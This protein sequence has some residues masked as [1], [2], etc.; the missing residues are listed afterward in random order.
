MLTFIIPLL[1]PR[2]SPQWSQTIAYLRETVRSI[3]AQK[4]S[5][6]QAVVVANREAELPGLPNRVEVVRVDLEPNPMYVIG[7]GDKE[8]FYEAV[9]LDKGQRL[10][11]GMLYSDRSGHF[12]VVDADDLVSN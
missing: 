5:D 11:A 12:M 1:H 3:A 7:A 8:P 4:S 9:R 6:W 2:N 10:L